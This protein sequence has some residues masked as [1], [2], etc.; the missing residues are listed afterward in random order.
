MATQA[1]AD[2]LRDQ[3]LFMVSLEVGKPRD[4]SFQAW[5]VVRG[6][7]RPPSLLDELDEPGHVARTGLSSA[8]GS[9]DHFSTDCPILR[10]ASDAHHGR[11]CVSEPLWLQ[12]HLGALN[13]EKGRDLWPVGQEPCFDL[14]HRYSKVHL[15]RGAR[16][17]V[18]NEGR[19]ALRVA[20]EI[21]KHNPRDYLRSLVVPRQLLQQ[22]AF[23]VL[24]VDG[25]VPVTRVADE[26]PKHCLVDH[27]LHRAR[28]DQRRLSHFP[29]KSESW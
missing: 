12:W 8:R 7:D 5:G 20:V 2:A 13:S 11:L 4:A 19:R 28:D 18:L 27:A 9:R 16:Q 23:P 26:A 22:S 14:P 15:W 1:T 17:V 24:Y 21:D 6:L 3:E 10:L 29:E 25:P